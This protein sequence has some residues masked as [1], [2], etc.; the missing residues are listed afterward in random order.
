MVR[1]LTTKTLKRNPTLK[2]GR[3]LNVNQIICCRNSLSPK[4]W[5]NRGSA[6]KSTSSLK[7][8]MLALSNTI[9]SMSARTRKLSKSTLRR[10]KPAKSTRKIFSCRISAK[11]IY[12]Q[13]QNK[14]Q[15]SARLG[16]GCDTKEMATQQ[17]TGRKRKGLAT[18]KKEKNKAQRWI[19]R[20]QTHTCDRNRPIKMRSASGICQVLR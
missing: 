15:T 20:E 18:G 17:L 13:N 19:G 14:K 2:S 5:G 7:M 4:M 12:C 3:R 8:T 16:H 6:H 10:K 1:R 11:N 9:L